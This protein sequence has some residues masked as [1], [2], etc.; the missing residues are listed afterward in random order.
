MLTARAQSGNFLVYQESRHFKPEGRPNNT[1]PI[2]S[3]YY[4]HHK[5]HS[6][7]KKGSS[8]N[9][10]STC[11]TPYLRLLKESGLGMERINQHI[12]IQL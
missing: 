7:G 8:Q 12:D 9:K 2:H 6:D 10:L 5:L 3:Q 4:D 11:R 1:N